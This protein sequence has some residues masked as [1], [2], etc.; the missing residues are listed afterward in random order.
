MNKKISRLFAITLVCSMIA[1]SAPLVLAKPSGIP[2][3]SHDPIWVTSQGRYYDTIVPVDQEKGLPWNEH[4]TG[5]FQQLYTAGGLSTDYGP[6][7]PGYRG[8]R[9][10]IDDNG[11]GYQDANDVYFLCPLLGGPVRYPLP[12]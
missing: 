10:W 4:N 5:S 9:W 11:N 8:G 6:G 2:R 12:Q 7:D 3:G 1:F